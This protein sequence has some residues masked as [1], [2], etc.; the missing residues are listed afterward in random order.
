MYHISAQPWIVIFSVGMIFTLYYIFAILLFRKKLEI[1]KPAETNLIY[2]FCVLIILDTVISGP[3]IVSNFLLHKI[4]SGF[5]G[6]YLLYWFHSFI[7][8]GESVARISLLYCKI[9]LLA[10]FLPVI[11]A[12]SFELYN[13]YILLNAE[14][15][16]TSKL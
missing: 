16:Q 3:G 13:I 12:L 2:L 8:C 14:K 4:S 6:L 1:P 15:Y 5:Y 9:I 7:L 11:T 10:D